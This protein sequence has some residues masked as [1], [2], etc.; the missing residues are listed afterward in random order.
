V[1]NGPLHA[2]KAGVS[3]GNGVYRYGASVVFPNSSYNS[4]NY[5][6]DVVFVA[7]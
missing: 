5:W 7:K 3:G 1:D 2:L 4:S 6:V